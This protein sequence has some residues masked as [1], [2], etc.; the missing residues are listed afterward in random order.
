MR[1]TL[2]L[3]TWNEIDGCRHDVRH[4]PLEHF[5]EVFAVDGGSTD[6]TCEYLQSH[7]IVVHAQNLPTYNG[8]YIRAFN[9]CT[10]D[11]L[12]LYQPKGTIDPA[13]VLKFRALFE[14]GADLVIASRIGE[15]ARNEE[16]S[17][18]IKHRKWFVIGLGL[19]ASLIWRRQGPIVWDVLHG[20]R[21]MRRQAFDSITPLPQGVSIDLE[22]VVRA[23]KRRLQIATFPVQERSRI[24][25]STHFKAWPTGKRLIKYLWSERSRP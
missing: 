25:G 13:S 14:E 8:A 3:L 2:C 10:T 16:D 4:L 1:L 20:F 22:M 7:G 11:A 19:V 9:L 12:V 23:Y 6:G 18:L 5:D 21:G 24:G 15:G 17:R